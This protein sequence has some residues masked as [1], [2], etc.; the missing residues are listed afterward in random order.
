MLCLDNINTTFFI[1]SDAVPSVLYYSHLPT[2]FVALFL[3]LFVYF[4]SGRNLL[5]K[6][7]LSISLSFSLWTFINLIIWTNSNSEWIIFLWSILGFLYIFICLS[8]LYFFCVYLDKQDINLIK[9][10]IFLLIILPSIVLIPTSLDLTSFDL[11]NCEAVENASFN[12]YYYGVGFLIFIWIFFLSFFRYWKSDRFARKEILILT[13]GVELFLLSFFTTG[14]LASFLNNF[15]LEQYGLFGMTF[16]MGVLAYMIVKFQAFNIK[17]IGTQALVFSLFILIASQ[18]AFIQNPINRAL[19]GITLILL[20]IFGYSLINSVKRE[21]RQREALAVANREISERKEELQ[22][23]SDHLSE[24]NAKLKELDNAKTEF[25]SIVAHQL[26]SPPTTIKGYS[27]LLEEGS[28]G[29]LS[30]EQKDVIKK[31]YNANEQ[32]VEFVADLLSVSRLESGRVSFNFENCQVQDIC[33]E[34]VDNLVIKAKEKGLNLEFKRPEKIL[35]EIKIDR[36]KIR[37]SITNLVDNAIKYTKRG[38]VVISLKGC[39]LGEEKCLSVDH[40]RIKVSDTGIGIPADEIPYLFSKFS[41]GKDVKR[42]N[43]GGTG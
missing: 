35:P 41:R 23:I 42:L 37:E 6:V 32:Q 3:G 27:K 25:V 28:Y 33:Q 15:E 39:S 8:V 19:T 24:A 5:G 11:T 14:Y 18:F 16:F 29:E 1:F 40:L 20:T 17:L 13:V 30:S 9:K 21:V 2:I 7:L 43:A 12:N 22:K 31:I 4:K 36:A 34:V 38:G 10:L 26:Q